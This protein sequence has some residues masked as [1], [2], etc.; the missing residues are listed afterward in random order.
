VDGI[1][2]LEHWGE[3]VDFRLGIGDCRQ[4]QEAINRPRIELGLT[5]LGPTS[6]IR[7]LVTGDAWPH[8]VREILRLGLVGAGMKSDRALVLVKRHVDPAGQWKEACAMAATVLGAALYGPPDDPVGKE[9]T[10]AAPDPPATT[11]QSGSL[12][13]TGSVL[14]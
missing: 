4:L 3:P 14:Q 10:P 2:T 13:S 12:K 7:L 9:T 11:S 6:L 8:E 1:V 5:A